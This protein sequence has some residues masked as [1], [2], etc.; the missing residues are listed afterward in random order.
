MEKINLATK[1]PKLKESQP[2]HVFFGH[3]FNSVET[4]E[5]SDTLTAQKQN[6]FITQAHILWVDSKSIP[7]AKTGKFISD[8]LIP[9]GVAFLRYRAKKR[10]DHEE[11]K[12]IGQILNDS[13]LFVVRY[14]DYPSD[15]Q[16]PANNS[17]D[18]LFVLGKMEPDGQ[19]VDLSYMWVATVYGSKFLCERPNIDGIIKDQINDK[20]FWENKNQFFTL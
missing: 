15:I 1:F 9:G 14:I 12:R 17:R 16:G 6:P 11:V 4:T 19:S 2:D 8:N 3:T 7:G 20:E 10:A 5:D 13:K 18:G